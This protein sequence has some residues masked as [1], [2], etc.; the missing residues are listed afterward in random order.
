MERRTPIQVVIIRDPADRATDAYV[1]ALELAFEGRARNSNDAPQYISDAVDLQIHVL[2]PALDHAAFDA[3]A[4]LG[5]AA[6]TIVV[7]IRSGPEAVRPPAQQRFFDAHDQADSGN[8]AR[9][10]VVTI[11]ESKVGATVQRA[12]TAPDELEASLLPVA[13]ALHA[14]ELA[15]RTLEAADADGADAT[16]YLKFFVSHAKIDGV[17]AALSLIGLMRRLRGFSASSMG[18]TTPFDYFYD[19]EDIPAGSDWKQVLE[20]NARSSVLIVLRTEEYQNRFWCRSEYH[21]AEEMGLPILVVDLRTEQ[22]QVADRLPFGVATAVRIGDGN[23]LRAILH[24][25]ASHVRLMRDRFMAN[26][27]KQGAFE[28]LPRHPSVISLAG[29]MKRLEARS[30]GNTDARIYYPSPRLPDVFVAAVQPMLSNDDV[31]ARLCS[32]DDVG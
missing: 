21:W 5:A 12:S 3:G 14:L 8:A 19:V 27:A 11:P 2:T 25:S 13:T 30:T 31:S 28:V 23:L 15:R 20:S 1:G 7:E 9:T 16:G 6:Y 24:A 22:F 18:I 29:A 10:L 26:K 32:M 4:L 17:P